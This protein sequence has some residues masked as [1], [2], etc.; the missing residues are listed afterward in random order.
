MKTQRIFPGVILIGFGLYFFLEQSQVD[1]FPGFYT[2]PTLL[3]I[4]GIAFLAQAYAGKDNES[5]LPGVIL[6]GF[7]LHFHMIERFKAWPDHIG[8]FILII[9]LGFI[10]KARKTNSGM[11]HG[12]LLLVVSILTLFYDKVFTWLGTL[13]SSFSNALKFWPFVLIAAGGYMLFFKKK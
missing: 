7:G 12:L 9:A 6:F 11:F 2:W 10:L 3:C 5:I 4:V 13:E 1:I 8:I